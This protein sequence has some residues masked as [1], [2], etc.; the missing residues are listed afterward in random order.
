MSALAFSEKPVC[1][2]TYVVD[3]IV[4]NRV[5]VSLGLGKILTGTCLELLVI[6]I[7]NSIVDDQ[8]FTQ[9][10]IC[11]TPNFTQV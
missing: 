11:L 10:A 1:P 5:S 6:L 8:I 2:I 9:N 7:T 3:A 4:Q